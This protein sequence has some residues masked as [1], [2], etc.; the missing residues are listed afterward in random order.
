[1]RAGGHLLPGSDR[2]APAETDGW[3]TSAC[4]SPILGRHIALGMLR[5]G[6][7]RY[8]EVLTLFDEN[9]SYDVK[10]VS[11]VFYDPD[12]QRLND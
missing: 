9:E 6:R 8:G 10:V 4:F 7:K 12:N 2:Q 11:P 3:I 1:M 5:D